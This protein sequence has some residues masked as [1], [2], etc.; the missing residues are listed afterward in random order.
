MLSVERKKE[1]K[2]GED[3]LAEHVR[4]GTEGERKVRYHN[5]T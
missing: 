4:R 2:K 5:M 3:T 1:R